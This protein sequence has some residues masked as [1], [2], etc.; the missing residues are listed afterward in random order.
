MAMAMKIPPTT[1]LLSLC[2]TL[3]TARPLPCQD[4]YSATVMAGISNRGRHGTSPYVTAGDRAYL[5]GTQDGNFPDMG[6]HVPG[7]MGGL[8]LH[9][10]KL[11]DGFRAAVT[12][13][14]TDREVTLSESTEFINYP[15]GNR[16]RYGAALDSL[17]VERFQ[18]GPDRQPGLVVQYVFTNAT[19]RPRRLGFLLSVKTDL[20]PVW[21]SERLGI[22]DGRDSVGWQS[23]GLFIARDTDN[24]WFC[25]W[26]VTPAPGARAVA[27]PPPIRTNGMGVTA[28]SRQTVSVGPHA[29]ST[30]TV[31]I[32]GSATNRDSAVDA[33]RYLAAHHADLLRTKKAHYASV[34][35]RARVR[36]PDQHLQEVYNWVRVDAEWLV[37]DVPGMGRGLGAGLLEYPWW[38]GTETYSLQAL[39]SAGGAEIAKE[40]LGLLKNQS[41]KT[42]GNGRIIHEVTTNGVV[43]NPGNTQET[44]QFILTVGQVLDW[45]GDMAFAREMYPAMKRGLHWLLTDMDRNKDLF[46]EGYG[47]TEVTGLDAE[48]IDVAV[49]TQRALEATARVADMMQESDSAAR[50]RRLAAELKARINNRFWLEADTSYADFYGTRDQAVSAA[51]GAVRQIRLADTLTP[52]D[53]E[54]IAYYERLRDRYAAMPD[55]SRGWLTNRNGVTLTPME[56]GIAPRARAIGLLEKTRREDVGPYG[57]FLSAVERQA[58]MTIGTGALAVAES[59]YGRTDEALWYMDK[60]VNTFNRVTP[61]S[62]SEMMPDYGCFVIAWTAYGIVVPLVRHVFGIE[63]DAMHKTVVLAPHVPRGWDDMSIESL[64]IGATSIDFSRARTDRGIEYR[65]DGSD[66]GWTFILRLE[67]SPG[68][69]YYLNGKPIALPPSGIRMS[70]THNRVLVVE[71]K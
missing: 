1:P 41:E 57:P 50:Y 43:Y 40:T 55:T 11:I 17:E 68:A 64:P 48:L 63:P 53:R 21:Q 59:N 9:P 23:D 69:T 7:E 3:A 51:V 36:I 24:P 27:D 52:R 6:D 15:Y 8:W 30:L 65:V 5:V 16:F 61:G 62:I 31:V 67:D 58:T 35:D 26:G 18:F 44:S 14:E 71:A 66:G 13:L 19:A 42:N 39:M 2:L 47:I 34:I 32:A 38:F 54:M 70:G 37:R 25:A 33:Y 22:H 4:D 12:D 46:P 20:R 28:A 60:I 29:T 45:T 49:Y 10:I 56:M